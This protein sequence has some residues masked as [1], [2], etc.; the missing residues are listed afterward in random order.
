MKKQ[1]APAPTPAPLPDKSSVTILGRIQNLLLNKNN[2]YVLLLWGVNNAVRL[3]GYFAIAK[4][5]S[6]ENFIIYSLYF[7]CQDLIVLGVS[8]SSQLYLLNKKIKH[9]PKQMRITVLGIENTLSLVFG[10][11]LLIAYMVWPIIFESITILILLIVSTMVRL[12]VQFFSRVAIL[13]VNLRENL[14]NDLW[15]NCLWV[16]PATCLLI[17]YDDISLALILLVQI[18]VGFMFLAMVHG[19]K[20]L[21]LRDC[22]AAKNIKKRF[23]H[24]L[25]FYKR[26]ALYSMATIGFFAFE[27]LLFNEL[28]T[29]ETSAVTTYLLLSKMVFFI[30]HLTLGVIAVDTLN[31]V[32]QRK[33][34][35]PFLVDYHIRIGVNAVISVLLAFTYKIVWPYLILIFPNQLDDNYEVFG[36]WV[37]ASIAFYQMIFIT[38]IYIE[39]VFR[40]Q[41]LY[42]LVA[43]LYI[44][45]LAAV[46]LSNTPIDYLRVVTLFIILGFGLCY[47]SLH[48]NKQAI[49]NPQQNKRTGTAG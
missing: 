38:N 17:I 49:M 32:K 2:L 9:P 15:G 45:P 31:K 40:Y 21:W 43:F 4:M 12:N 39:S 18:L 19:K 16:V 28:F 25:G 48:L 47:L 36:Y 1:A 7:I 13:Y 29:S 42:G 5:L 26:T 30:V 23:Q 46:L 27:K 8:N 35:V 20:L 34:G 11:L 37:I 44:G 14:R 24:F 10:L 6:A 22:F 3:I 41:H 33:A